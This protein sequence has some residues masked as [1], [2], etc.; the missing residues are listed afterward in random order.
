VGERADRVRARRGMQ[1]AVVATAGKLCVLGWHLITRSEGYAFQRPSLTKKKLRALELRAGM[2]SHD[3]QTGRAATLHPG[4]KDTKP[5]IT[6]E[7]SRRD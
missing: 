3:G 7:T 2:P 6:S 1:A 4:R 5:M